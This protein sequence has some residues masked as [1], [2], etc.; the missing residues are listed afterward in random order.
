MILSHAAFFIFEQLRGRREQMM[1]NVQYFLLSEALVSIEF[2]DRTQFASAM[3][4]NKA[5]FRRCATV[6]PK[7]NLNNEFS[8]ARL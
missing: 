8:S 4:L 3:T 2:Q 7:S 1:A 6:V 5:R